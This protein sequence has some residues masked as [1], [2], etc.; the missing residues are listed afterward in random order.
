MM[1]EAIVVVR[2]KTDVGE[3]ESFNDWGGGYSN[4]DIPDPSN[5]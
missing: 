1:R 2:G 3:S 5:R 4:S